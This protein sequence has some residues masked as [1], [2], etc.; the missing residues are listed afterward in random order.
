MK[1]L[2]SILLSLVLVGCLSVGVFAASPDAGIT[3]YWTNTSMIAPSISPASGNYSANIVGNP[4]TTK[5]SCTMVLYEK[6][7]FG[8]K[9]VSRKSGSVDEPAAFFFE[10]Y[11]FSSGKT[12]LLEVSSTV[13]IAGVDETANISFE[14]KA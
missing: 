3:P 9:E 1:K 5:I 12:Y 8:Y 7:F 11:S 10:S 6:G 13:R 4:G 14:K 2:V